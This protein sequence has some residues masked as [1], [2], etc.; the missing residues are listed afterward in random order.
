[1][2]INSLPPQVKCENRWDGKEFTR[3]SKK[4][5]PSSVGTDGGHIVAV[6]KVNN[7]FF[8]NDDAKDIQAVSLEYIQKGFNGHFIK[9]R[10]CATKTVDKNY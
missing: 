2:H 8:V 5:L 4:I 9:A 10:I 3:E 7:E 6:T 1:M